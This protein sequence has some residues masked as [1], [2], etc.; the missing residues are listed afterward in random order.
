MA[1]M[2]D[3][4]SSLPKMEKMWPLLSDDEHETDPE[5]EKSEEERLKEVMRKVLE[6]TQKWNK[7]K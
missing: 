1:V 2:R 5:Y 6:S 7:K 3:R 4:K